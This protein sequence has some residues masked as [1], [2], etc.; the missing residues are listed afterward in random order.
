LHAVS[1]T[2]LTTDVRPV[3]E[4]ALWIADLLRTR[5]AD[6]SLVCELAEVAAAALRGYPLAKEIVDRH[7]TDALGSA[8]T[9][10]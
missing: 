8:A 10:G 2:L 5:G 9:G 1:A 7:F 3:P 4:T 6:P